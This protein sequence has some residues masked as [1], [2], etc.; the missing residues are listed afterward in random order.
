MSFQRVV[1]VAAVAVMVVA[2]AGLWIGFSPSRSALSKAAVSSPDNA[3]PSILIAHASRRAVPDVAFED[4]AG[5]KRTLADFRGRVVLLNLW[6]TW[7]SPCRA[8]M[9][10]L[11]RLQSRLGGKDFEVVA[12][13]IDREGTP[14][15]KRFFDETGVHSLAVYVDPTMEA[16]GRLAAVGI[17]TTVVIDRQGREVARKSGPAAWDSPESIAFIQRYIAAPTQEEKDR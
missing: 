6:A 3:K 17:P 1:M 10:T 7:C 14:I 8:E 11:D 15:V 12:L 13:S 5:R 2:A 9:P 4:A 16:Q